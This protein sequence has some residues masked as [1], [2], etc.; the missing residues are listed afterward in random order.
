[1]TVAALT[2]Y[3]TPFFLYDAALVRDRVHE[4]QAAFQSMPVQLFYAVKA[5]DHPALIRLITENSGVGACLVSAGEMRRATAAGVPAARMLMNGVG[6]TD[7]EIAFALAEGIGQLNIEALP[8]IPR[9]A[10]IATR[11]GRRATV[12]LRLNPEVKASTHSHITT[13]RRDDKFGL[14]LDELPAARALLAAHA[15]QLDWRGFS[16]HIGSQIHAVD[17]LA[18]SYRRMLDLFRAERQSQPQ[19]D[20]LDLGGGFGVS[21]SGNPAADKAYASNIY[22]R[23]AAYAALLQELAADLLA[24]GVT[25][26]LEPGRFLVAECGQLIT[27]VVQ[28][29]ESGGTRFVVLDAAMNN[30][31][32]PALYGARHPVTAINARTSKT[33][34]AT[35]VGPVCESSDCFGRDY[36]LPVDVAAGDLLAIGMAGAYGATMSSQYNARDRLAEVLVD[37][38]QHRLIR[39]AFSAADYDA[40]TL[41]A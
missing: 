3:Q 29:K 28:V 34:P 2:S 26:Q 25:L 15:V 8:E 40:A 13:A 12:C 33:A 6:K 36:E 38:G 37:G 35:L 10:A 23:P 22:A 39:R 30:L 4:L 27:R 11:L 19:F 31:L 41:V 24:A 32:R 16:C 1:M 18:A 9:I 17:E 14:L 20:R 7:D 5:N 21:Y